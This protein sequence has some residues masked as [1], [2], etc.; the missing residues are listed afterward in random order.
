LSEL[1]RVK[2]QLNVDM[3][4]ENLVSKHKDRILKLGEE[5]SLVS[6]NQQIELHKVKA[7]VLEH[8]NMID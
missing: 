4:L 5:T 1:E 6:L 3:A 7:Q 8:K 2:L